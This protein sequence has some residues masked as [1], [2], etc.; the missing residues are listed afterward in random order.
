MRS[1][2]FLNHLQQQIEEVKSEGLYKAERV[3]TSQQFSD[4]TVQGEQVLNFCANNYLGLANSAELIKAAQQGLD[5]HGFGV[6]SVRFICGTQD[7]HKQL[8]AKISE[9]FRH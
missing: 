5:S 8:E 3:I 2:A 1:S 9:F 7:I 6:A 4:V